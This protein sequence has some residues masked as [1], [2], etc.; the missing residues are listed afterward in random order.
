M[1][2]AID[3]NRPLPPANALG[4]QAIS[5]ALGAWESARHAYRRAS[6]DLVVLEQRRPEAVALDREALADAL[7]ADQEDPGDKFTES[8]DE[9]IAEATRR[10]D[11]LR[12]LEERRWSE[13]QAAFEEHGDE[14]AANAREKLDQA[15][16]RFTEALAVAAECHAALVGA[17]AITGFAAGH[18]FR[19]GWLGIVKVADRDVG[20]SEIFGALAA[21]IPEREPERLA[22]VEDAKNVA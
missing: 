6:Q 4:V 20:V 11:A 5:D 22:L 1:S 3:R 16:A 8:H 21:L 14:I 12:L 7:E 15:R 19:S 9:R 2:I 10:I 18:G 17:Q 13:V